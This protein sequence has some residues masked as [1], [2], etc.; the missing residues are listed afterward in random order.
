MFLNDRCLGARIAK[1]MVGHWGDV[2]WFEAS[3][4]RYG[5]AIKDEYGQDADID[6]KLN[7]AFDYASLLVHW[8]DRRKH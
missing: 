3:P 2:P 5:A 6:Q 7:E 1:E 8:R 4:A